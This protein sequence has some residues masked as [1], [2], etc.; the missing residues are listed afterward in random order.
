MPLDFI[1]AIVA[2]LFAGLV[3]SIVGGGGLIL[4]PA[5]FATFP[6][7]PPATLLGTNKAASVWGTLFSTIQYAQRVTIQ[8]RVLQPAALITALASLV[9]AWAVTQV[10]GSILRK[11]LPIILLGV[12]IYTIS[13]KHLGAVHAPRF[14]GSR[15]LL[16]MAAIGISIGFYDGFFGP[17]AGSFYMFLFVRLLGYDFLNAS[18]NAKVL[19]LASNGTALV[20]LSFKGHVW[21]QIALAMAVSNVMGSLIGTKLAL[22]YGA[23]FVRVVFIVVVAALIIKTGTA[24]YL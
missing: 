6:N 14:K 9:G 7:M 13:V 3:D 24:A 8:W 22:R 21:W 4:V 2:S 5:L 23:K 19:N 20:L 15:E 17:G 1:I 11:A 18:A 12:L 16:A 10:D